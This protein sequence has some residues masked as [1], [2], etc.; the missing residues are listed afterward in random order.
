MLPFTCFPFISESLSLNSFI[1][2]H[3]F[4]SLFFILYTPICSH[5]ERRFQKKLLT[6]GKVGGYNGGRPQKN[7]MWVRRGNIIREPHH[8]VSDNF[9]IWELIKYGF[10][11]E[12]VRTFM[13]INMM[14]ISTKGVRESSNENCHLMSWLMEWIF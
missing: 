12:T 11:L 14:L 6:P 3:L 5:R 7:K 10:M 8:H 2:F 9:R 1:F 13:K 4:Y